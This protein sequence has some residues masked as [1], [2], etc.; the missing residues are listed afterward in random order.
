MSHDHWSYYDDTFDWDDSGA[1]MRPDLD[2]S[3]AKFLEAGLSA[4]EAQRLVASGYFYEKHTGNII[5]RYYGGLFIP[6]DMRTRFPIGEFAEMDHTAKSKVQVRSARSWAEVQHIVD[7]I[8]Q[9]GS[10]RLLFRGQT[11]NYIT[12][13]AVP[14][15]CFVIEGLGE[16]SL[17]PSLWRQMIERNPSSFA[18]F[19]NLEHYDWLKILNSAFDLEDIN[20]RREAI[21][22]ENLPFY[23][24]FDFEE[25]GDPVLE[26]YAKCNLDVSMGYKFNL[27]DLL[28]T[29]LQHY[30]LYSPVLDLTESLDVAIFFATHRFQRREEECVYEFV[31][32]NSRRSVI[33]LLRENP[34]EMRTYQSDER[35]IRKLEPLRPKRQ[36]CMISTSGPHAL[37]LPA[38][39]LVAMI[40]LDFGADKL[41]S[42]SDSAT[43]FPDDTQDAFLRALKSHPDARKYLS[44]FPTRV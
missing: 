43:L 7:E 13:R 36:Q 30:G 35:I 27:A 34:R 38:D 15:P 14:N 39:F 29:L 8:A 31:G 20:R 23:N 37:N 44:D 17:V 2:L 5:D 10:R 32:T 40:R 41:G 21:A 42:S 11:E 12:K 4:S 3:R 22:G 24:W 25:C 9:A 19:Q 6:T 28:A 33:Y 18:W 1:E 26:E 16:V